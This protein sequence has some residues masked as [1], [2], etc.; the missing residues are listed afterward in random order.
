MGA[1]TVS[2]DELSRVVGAGGSLSMLDRKLLK[3]ASKRWTLEVMSQRL[4]GM[5]TPAQCGQRVR[6]ILRSWDWLAI[7]E[8][9]AL[10]LMD[11]IELKEIL[12]DRV[13]REGGVVQD[14]SGRVAYSFGDPR[15]ATTLNNTLKEM[16]KLISG[17]QTTVEAD[18]AVLRAEHAR[19]MIQAVEKFS[20]IFARGLK[21]SYPEIDAK[22]MRAT[23]EEALPQA[24]AIIDGATDPEEFGD[25]EGGF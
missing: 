5:L 11:F 21:E 20:D 16:N 22:V 24:I 8:Q 9:Q 4:G 18:R 17:M 10:I 2:A 3:Y 25:D 15:W 6:E 1:T 12:L 19:P 7:N 14:E 13:R 23:I